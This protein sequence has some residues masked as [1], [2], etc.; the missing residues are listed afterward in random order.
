MAYCLGWFVVIVTV[1]CRFS[2]ASQGI[3]VAWLT[4]GLG[5]TAAAPYSQIAGGV[6]ALS[7]PSTKNP[8]SPT[9]VPF[10]NFASNEALRSSAR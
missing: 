1:A 10:A 9:R 6:A 2:G 7:Y 5:L 8:Q 3:V 4:V